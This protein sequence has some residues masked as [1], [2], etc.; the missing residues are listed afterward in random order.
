MAGKK[1]PPSEQL[2]R[3]I[4]IEKRDSWDEE[5]RC[6]EVAFSSE[7]PYERWWG[8]EILGHKEGEVR[9]ERL[10]SGAAPLLHQHNHG[11]QI[12]VVERAWVDADGK[13]RCI[14][15]FSK[16]AQAEEIFRDVIDG[17]RSNISVGYQVHKAVLVE[18]NEEQEIYRMTD[19]EPF[20]VS[21]VSVPADSTVGVGRSHKP[22]IINEIKR[23]ES[24]MPEAVKGQTETTRSQEKREEKVDIKKIAEDARAAELDRIRELTAIGQAHEMREAAE[25]FISRGKSVDEFRSFVLDELARRGVKPVETVSSEIGMSDGEARQFSFMRA[26]YALANPGNR[27]AQEAAAFE[28]DASAAVAE[29][30]GRSAKG[31]MVPMEVLSAR[32]GQ[33]VNPASAGG[34]LVATNLLTGSFIDLLRNKMLLAR[35]GITTLT[36]LVGDIA[37]PK[38]LSGTACYWVDEG[39]DPAESAASFGQVAMIPKTIGART[40]ISRKL[41]LQ[42]SLDIEAFIRNDLATTVALGIDAAA[43]SGKG[44]GSE[45]K[46][47]LKNSDIAEVAIGANG[48]VIS[49]SKVVELWSKVA[50][51]NADVGNTGF[52]TNSLVCGQLMTTEKSAGTAKFLVDGFPGAD[53]FV[54]L[55]GGRCGI[56]NQMPHN[57][58]KGT[59]K[60]LSALIFGNFADLMVGMW[61]TLDLT[62]DPYS[63]AESGTVRVIALQDVDVAIKRA[64]SFAAIKDIKTA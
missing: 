6:V 56:T 31:I 43:I 64:Q 48:G 28:Y 12:G 23:E 10:A 33:T 34:N 45:P 11:Q 50:L 8:T 7:E 16:S 40:E 32:A 60:D 61:G 2:Y 41:L 63:K 3:S 42:S 51:E 30:M 24:V 18:Q 9:L 53:G 13:G 47:L 58:T 14:V 22:E 15:R 4:R 54:A 26:I 62:I 59:G 29:K 38:Q 27:K 21:F 55:A 17:I 1:T 36:G 35:M 49:W 44:T 37:V 52:I 19:W 57:L 39:G 20:E 25:D 5:K 46:G